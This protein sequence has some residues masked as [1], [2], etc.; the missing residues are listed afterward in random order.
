MAMPFPLRK[1]QGLAMPGSAPRRSPVD[2]RRT[3]SFDGTSL[4]VHVVGEGRP[5]LL[6][7]G[8]FSTAQVNWIRP[9]TARRLADAGWQVVMPDLRGHGESDSPATAEGWPADVLARDAEAVADAMGLADPVL[10][11]YSL[12]G[13]TVVRCLARGLRPHAAI[14][15]GMGLAGITEVGP[16]S[17]WF[18]RMIAGRGSWKPGSSEYFAE[19]FMK[20]NV[21][22]P[23]NLL[24]LLRGQVD[25]PRERLAELDVP[26]L[27]VAGAE[28]FDNGSARDLAGA[29]PDA[30]FAEIPG[31]HMSAVTRPELAEAMLAFL[32][33]LER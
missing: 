28:D 16:R 4:A 33:E 27:V 1:G 2:T 9:G 29:L 5:M 31:T 19:A 10:G 15:A 11:G 20:A 23:E 3:P 18:C 7:H 22:A 26:T 6:L 32:A 25:T 14:V 17:D 12:G 24:H 21:P 30:R 13:R 8:L